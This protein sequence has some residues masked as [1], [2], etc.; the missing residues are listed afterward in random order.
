MIRPLVVAS[1]AALLGASACGSNDKPSSSSTGADVAPDP[2]DAATESAAPRPP[3]AKKRLRGAWG[4]IEVDGAFRPGNS[5]IPLPAGMTADVE[6][7]RYSEGGTALARLVIVHRDVPGLAA[8]PEPRLADSAGDLLAGVACPGGSIDTGE[9]VIANNER[10]RIQCTR[11]SLGPGV[12]ASA[13][14]G[15]RAYEVICIEETDALR[16][17]EYLNTFAPAA[18][19]PPPR[20]P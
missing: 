7:V 20:A 10:A 12:V 8:I 15:T 14:K 9:I 5:F 13:R 16:C 1:F 11:S 4:T 19:P 3:P 18:A 2:S 6:Y 17:I